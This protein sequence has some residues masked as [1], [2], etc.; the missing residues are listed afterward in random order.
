MISDRMSARLEFLDRRRFCAVQDRAHLGS[1]LDARA[2]L[3]FIGVDRSETCRDE[4][5]Q[6]CRTCETSGALHFTV[7]K[8][9]LW[10]RSLLD[11][12]AQLDTSGRFPDGTRSGPDILCGVRAP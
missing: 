3:L 10:C 8:D 11:P 9:R 4:L 6:I 5:R 12:V 2:L 7:A 1:R